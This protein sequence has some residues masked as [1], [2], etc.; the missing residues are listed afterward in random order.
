MTIGIDTNSV[1]SLVGDNEEIDRR[2]GPFGSPLVPLPVLAESHFAVLNSRRR[3]ENR[4][5]LDDFLARA[6]V[7]PL[8]TETARLY[9][10]IRYQLKLKG[11]PIQMNDM[12]IAA[13]CLEHNVPLLTRDSDFD[14]VDGL[15]VVHW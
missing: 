13:V 7:P 10:E 11:R 8:T 14:N 12:W 2:V 15:V 3:A 5:R 4:T 9:A 6:V 1:W